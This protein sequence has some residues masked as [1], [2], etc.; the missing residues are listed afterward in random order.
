MKKGLIQVYTGNGKG[1]TTA[2][3]GQMVRATGR[4]YKV[5]MVYWLKEEGISGEMEI[6]KK[7]GVKILFWGGKYGKKLVTN[8]PLGNIDKIKE[9]SKNF[10]SQLKEQI[11]KEGYDLLILD[12][13]NIALSY[14]LVEEKEVLNFLK[15]KPPSL[16]IILTGR[17]APERILVVADLVTEMKKI[18]HPH[19]RGIKMRKG[20]EY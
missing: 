8:T 1:K 13:I 4:G 16:E 20:I 6:L 9:D 14:D 10:L 17:K 11:K 12:E 5:M 2:A 18:K 3:V 15:D 19:D 7:L